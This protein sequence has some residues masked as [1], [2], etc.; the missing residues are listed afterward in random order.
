LQTDSR[1]LVARYKQALRE[2]R[3]DRKET[4][5]FQGDETLTEKQ[6][7]RLMV[8]ND[9]LPELP[10]GVRGIILNDKMTNVKLKSS[11]PKP[12]TIE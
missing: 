6:F 2:D 9:D 12:V 3:E 5:S 1:H 8:L 4:S 11:I 7:K 10:T